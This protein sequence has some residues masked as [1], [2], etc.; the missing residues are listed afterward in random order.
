MKSLPI[1]AL[2]IGVADVSIRLF[3]FIVF[4]YLARTLG[5]SDIGVLAVGMAILTYIVDISSNM[6]EDIELEK[7]VENY[8]N[9]KKD[10]HIKK[11]NNAIVKGG[12]SPLVASHIKYAGLLLL[13]AI[14]SKPFN[15]LNIQSH[16]ITVSGLSQSLEQ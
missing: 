4:T 11:N 10:K 3:S 1:N 9:I 14:S 15:S 12:N 5:P 6:K 8:S 16:N 7:K 2:F 13:P